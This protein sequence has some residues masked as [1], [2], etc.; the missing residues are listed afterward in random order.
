MRFFILFYFFSITVKIW[1][2]KFWFWTSTYIRKLDFECRMCLE[3]LLPG[4][5]RNKT[6]NRFA[7]KHSIFWPNASYTTYGFKKKNNPNCNE[8]EA[9][10]YPRHPCAPPPCPP[11]SDRALL[12]GTSGAVAR[13][14][15]QTNDLG[16]MLSQ[17]ERWS[18]LTIGFPNVRVASVL[19]SATLLLSPL[20]TAELTPGNSQLTFH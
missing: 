17:Q 7:F 11:W 2:R 18:C 6:S 16:E 3:I 14:R 10:T 4:T 9:V 15:T 20:A 8:R 1:I 13:C 5:R 12:A 19:C